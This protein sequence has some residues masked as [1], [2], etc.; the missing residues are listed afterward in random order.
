MAD[1]KKVLILSMTSGFGHVRAGEA[2]LDYAKEHLPEIRA[3]H[4]DVVAIDPAL[5]KYARMYDFISKKFPGLWKFLYVS[6][7][8]FFILKNLVW[9]RGLF[10]HRVHEYISRKQP[11]QIIFTNPIIAPMAAWGYKKKHPKTVIGMVVTDY[12]GHPYY[13]FR[14]IDYY[15]VAAGQV[16][17]DLL[18][19]GISPEKIKIT[20]IPI[21]PRFYV[22]RSVSELKK[23]YG[24]DNGLPVALL[25]TSFKIA[26]QELLDLAEELLGL[27]PPVNVVAVCNGNEQW[28]QLFK[29]H[30]SGRDRFSVVKWTVAM[31]E[32]MSIADAVISKAGGLTVSECLALSKPLIMV[33]PI[34]GQE[35]YNAGFMEEGGFGVRSRV[36]DVPAA[37]A[38]I[39]ASHRNGQQP[40]IEERNACREIFYYISHG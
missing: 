3:E 15:F 39:I 33:N 1:K 9:L 31:E 18:N 40:L 25:V 7:A 28:Y 23:Q 10:F 11:D 37:V 14:G 5:A 6:P 27:R 13:R 36:S 20:G 24:V 12:H 30:F 22:K 19:L 2:L 29:H 32:Y 4:V 26:Q 17:E 35:V 8:T 21:S 16:Q 34:P 38:R